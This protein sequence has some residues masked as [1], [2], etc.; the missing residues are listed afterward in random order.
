MSS[1]P[2]LAGQLGPLT[3]SGG[4]YLNFGHKLQSLRRENRGG[5]GADEGVVRLTRFGVSIT[6]IGEGRLL[7]II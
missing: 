5:E 7:Y 3:I 6:Y 1:N 4:S 2:R